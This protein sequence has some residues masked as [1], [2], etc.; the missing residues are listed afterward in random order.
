M[1]GGGNTQR[2]TPPL[3]LVFGHSWPL[4]CQHFFFHISA[5]SHTACVGVVVVARLQFSIVFL[6]STEPWRRSKRTA[7]QT[8]SYG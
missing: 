2:D 8:Q 6:L 3:L 5:K 1:H 4:L 7:A